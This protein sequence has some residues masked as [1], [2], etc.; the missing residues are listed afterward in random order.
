MYIKYDEMPKIPS[1]LLINANDSQFRIF[2]TDDKITCFICKSTGHTSLTCKK[3]ILNNMEISSTPHQTNVTEIN[4]TSENHKIELIENSQPPNN[5]PMLIASD[6]T[7]ANWNNTTK[8]SAHKRQ[9]PQTTTSST[10][11]QPTLH[12]FPRTTPPR[13]KKSSQKKLKRQI[14]TQLLKLLQSIK[15]HFLLNQNHRTNQKIVPAQIRA[16]VFQ[17]I[18]TLTST[19]SVI[20]LSSIINLD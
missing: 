20:F 10:P 5:S 14:K 16:N 9:T 15:K 18:W 3:T 13:G 12:N 6:E 2:F 4:S 19:P 8:S 7:P 17:R 1:S 11:P